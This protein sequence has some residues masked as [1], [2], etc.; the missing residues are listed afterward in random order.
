MKK[1]LRFVVMIV[2]LLLI[3]CV[4]FVACDQKKTEAPQYEHTESET[5]K[6]EHTEADWIV[7]TEA[8]CT[9]A[10]LK[11]LQCDECGEQSKILPA[12]GHEW[13]NATCTVP[14][15]CRACDKQEGDPLGHEYQTSVKT[16]ASCTTAG[17]EK[18]VCT[19]CDDAYESEIKMLGH[20]NALQGSGADVCSTCQKETYT[21]YSVKALS[22][23][24]ASL[25]VPSSATIS[26]V[27][28]GKTQWEEKDA[29]AVVIAL[30]AQN[31]YGGMTSA[32][33]VVMFD[34]ATGIAISYDLVEAMQ[35]KADYYQDWANMSS[36]Q[37]K[38][39]YLNKA[40]EYLNK[41]I[42]ALNIKKNKATTL[43]LQD[44]AYI[45]PLAKA[46]SGVFN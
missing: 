45:D 30:S 7:A 43:K 24:Y 33:Y 4:L 2:V 18:H 5:P 44:L 31:S 36:G 23:I 26:S 1:T 38:I 20:S 46:S 34:L 8:G 17:V 11:V 42:T 35:D 3:G 41:K 37:S 27:Y 6:C 14:K 25:K 40:N 12:K 22:G 39:N 29:I 13:E 10:G 19:R 21:T 15:M 28:A 32:E 16:A 9:T